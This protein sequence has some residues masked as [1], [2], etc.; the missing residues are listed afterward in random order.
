MEEKKSP[1]TM[2]N[3]NI[4]ISAVNNTKNG[5]V[6]YTLESI[7]LMIEHWSSEKN[8]EYFLIEHREDIENIHFHLV[9]KFTSVTKFQTIKNK[10]PYGDIQ[11]S[12]SVN[13]SIQYLIHMNSPEKLQYLPSDIITNSMDLNKHLLKSKVSEELDINHYVSQILEGKI[14]EYQYSEKIPG[15]IYTKYSNRIDKAFKFYYDN[16]AMVSDRQISVEFI[17]G[18][19]GVGKTWFAKTSCDMNNE[20]YCISS[21]ANDPMQDYRGEDVLILD[22]LRDSSFKFDDLLKILDNHTRS[23]ISSRYRNKY[24]VGS[25]IIITSSIELK[26]WYSWIKYEDKHQLHRRIK[27]MIRFNSEEL[28]IYR[29]DEYEKTYKYIKKNENIFGTRITDSLE[30]S[31]ND[32]ISRF[33]FLI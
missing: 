21:S 32:D 6:N 1:K 24:F 4:R 18:K 15:L 8:L 25:R 27:T 19:G 29:Y 14:R 31:T 7:K 26:D 17:F 11:N 16:L 30:N 9:L 12:K 22:D 13:N 20:S 23:S 33:N 3:A 5:I 2:R 10:F 28:V